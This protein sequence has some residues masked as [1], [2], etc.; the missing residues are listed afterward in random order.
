MGTFSSDWRLISAGA[1]I[2][3]IPIIIVF[4]LLQKYFVNGLKG[5]I[6]G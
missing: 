2:S 6:K 5:A 1:I 3:V 4:V